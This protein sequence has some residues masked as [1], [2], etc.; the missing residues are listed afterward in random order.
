[1][2]DPHGRR[3]VMETVRRLNRERGIT[4]LY[5]THFMDEAAAADRVIVMDDGKIVIDDCPRA[6]F[7]QVERMKSLG[8]DVP[9]VTE[10]IDSLSRCGINTGGSVL[11]VD[12]CIDRLANLLE[13]A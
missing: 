6:V 11:D 3:E 10:M 8:L 9:Q 12:E 1:M 5:I 7:S 4:I 13:E 2:L